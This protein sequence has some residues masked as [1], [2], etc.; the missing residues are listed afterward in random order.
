VAEFWHSA[1]MAFALCPMLTAGAIELLGAHG[2]DAQKDLYLT[3]MISGEWTGTMN[4]TEPQAGS[5]LAQIRTRAVPDGNGNW[6]IHGQ[7]IFITYGEHDLTENIVHLVLARTP[8]APAGVRGISLFIVP[9]FLTDDQ[10][11]I[12][13]RNDVNTVSLEHKLG[14]HA[15][16]TAVLSFGDDGGALGYR[17]GEEGK[18]LAAM[19]TMMNNAR[20]AVGQQGI[21][22]G[23]RAYQQALDYA[24]NRIQ[25]RDAATGAPCRHCQNAFAYALWHRGRTGPGPLYRQSDGHRPSSQQRRPP[26]KR[27]GSC[28][29]A[30][31]D[32][33]GMVN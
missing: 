26:A 14:I 22:I 1:N 8:D 12:G 15:S 7:K 27:P 24:R 11:T 16:P 31:P 32:G 6:R 9:K 29:F 4:L 13:A 10:G 33:Q 28:R 3:R 21:A 30:D 18:G 19:F 2:S 5:D 25:G 23:E 20:L 17:V